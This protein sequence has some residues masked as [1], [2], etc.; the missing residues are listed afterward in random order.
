MGFWRKTVPLLQM[1]KFEHSVFALPFAV[2][3]ALYANP[4]VDLKPI[5][6]IVLA[7]VSARS[8]A[9]A[10]N[11]IAD[12]SIDAKNPRTAD[13]HLPKRILRPAEAWMFTI[14]M[15]GLFFLA[16][17]MLNETCLYCAPGVLVILLGYSYTKR[18]TWLC[19]FVLGLSLGLAPVGAWIGIANSIHVIPILMG[20]AVQ[21]W[22]AGFDIIYACL[23]A[24]FDRR[25]GVKSIPAR[26]GIRAG[27]V[28]SALSHIVC[29][30]LLIA[31]YFF[32]EPRGSIYLMVV[33]PILLVLAYQH[34]IV[35]PTD[36]QRANVA[37]F[38]ANVVVS[39]GVMA[40]LLLDLYA[41]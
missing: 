17:A 10:F 28:V 30:A 32:L 31:L 9:M 16:A 18:F 2:S 35:K 41:G 37:F 22:V 11:R 29:A 14:V 12:A 8:A 5:G 6:W 23:D 38:N 13:R 34:F 33:I 1:I 27:L 21:F 36:L 26:F 25:E 24:D 15:I 4:D 40:A 20:A 19:H 7:M 3:S 39:L